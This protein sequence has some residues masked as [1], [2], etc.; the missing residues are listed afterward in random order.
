LHYFHRH[1]SQSKI[2]PMNYSKEFIT[3]I[4]KGSQPSIK[5]YVK[6]RDILIKNK[7]QTNKRWNNEDSLVELNWEEK[8]IRSMKVYRHL[9]EQNE[10]DKE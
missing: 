8:K 10:E 4:P 3:E 2:N 1:K 6:H 7:K 5:Q 9:F